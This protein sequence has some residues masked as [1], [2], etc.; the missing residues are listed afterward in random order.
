MS[1]SAAAIVR[2][3][4]DLWAAEAPLVVSG[5]EMGAR[6]TLV[7]LGDGGLFVHSPGPLEDATR[8]A[9]EKLGQ[10]RAL[11]A[12]NQLHHMF[13]GDWAAAFPGARLFAA[14][15]VAAKRPELAFE[16]TLGDAPPPIWAAELDQHLVGGVPRMQ[17]VAFLHRASR[18][19]LLT[20]LCFNLRR[21]QS[22]FTR[23]FMRLN[24]AWGRFGPSRMMRHVVTR[25]RAALRASL[26]RILAWDFDRVI[27][28]HGDVL[29]RGG[30]EALRSGFAWLLGA[31]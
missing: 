15:G 4:R 28:T 13:L 31:A 29:E 24:G 20:D 26:E 5:L 14:P 3:D 7:R 18:T 12:P 2:L 25:D 16:A 6:T 22:R 11:V 23:V 17:E 19:L 30:R 10:V 21:S 9:V 27:V 1:S 8:A